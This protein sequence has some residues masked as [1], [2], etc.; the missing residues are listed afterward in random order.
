MQYLIVGGNS[1]AGKTAATAARAVDP[2][3]RIVAT[4]SGSGTVAGADQTIGGVDLNDP[5]TLDRVTDALQGQSL[6]ALFFTPAFGAIGYPVAATPAEDIQGSLAFS[7]DPMVALTDALKPELSV[8]YT[9]FY[10]LPH[11]LAA[12]GSMAY[13][14][15]AQEK[16]ALAE[17]DRYRMIRAGTFASK[18]TRGIGLLLQRQLRSTKHEELLAMGRLWKESGKKFGDFFFDYAFQSERGMCGDRFDA[19]H[20]ATEDA[21]LTRAARMILE[22]E[23][24]PIINV[25]GEWTWT[26]AALPELDPGQF[27]LLDRV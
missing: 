5:A 15:I 24:A 4:T 2:E 20:R 6:R 14:K 23:S 27:R 22:G 13:V 26:E 21:D 1:V 3:A 7:F 18:A 25:I 10:W 16:K 9:A 12:Y 19:P 11:T 17:P 8:G